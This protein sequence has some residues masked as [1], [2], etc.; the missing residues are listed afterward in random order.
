MP[1]I[2]NEEGVGGNGSEITYDIINN[3]TRFTPGPPEMKQNEAFGK[4][5]HTFWNKI[6]IKTT[7]TVVTHVID[8][9]HPKTADLVTFHSKS[10]KLKLK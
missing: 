5:I 6:N 8:H 2:P 7:V 1:D 9:Y 10:S 3:E 4:G